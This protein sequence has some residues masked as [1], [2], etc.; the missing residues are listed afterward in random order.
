MT[1]TASVKNTRK[2]Y[3]KDATPQYGLHSV[4]IIVPVTGPYAN[5]MR[6]IKEIEKS[7]TLFIINSIDVRAKETAARSSDIS[8]NLNLETFFYR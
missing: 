5:V 6:F 4:K 7:N 1:Q 8:M 3:N 2:E